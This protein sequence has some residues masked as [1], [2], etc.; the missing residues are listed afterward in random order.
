MKGFLKALKDHDIR[1]WSYFPSEILSTRL[2][3]ISSVLY[4]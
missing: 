2:K 3:T 1:F 4:I